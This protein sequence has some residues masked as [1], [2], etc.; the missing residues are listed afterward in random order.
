MFLVLAKDGPTCDTFQTKAMC[1]GIHV[2]VGVFVSKLSQG[3]KLLFGGIESRPKWLVLK[4]DGDM[5]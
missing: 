5:V 1:T 4:T 2:S 3:T